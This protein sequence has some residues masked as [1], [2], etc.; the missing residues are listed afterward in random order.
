MTDEAIAALLQA[1]DETAWRRICDD[2]G[3]PLYRYCYWLAGA[4]AAAAED[5]RQETFLAAMAG[6]AG[7]RGEVPLFAW[8]SGIARHKASDARRRRRRHMALD[9]AGDAPAADPSPEAG[10]LAAERSAGVVETLWSLPPD[11]RIALLARY[12]E[13]ESVECVAARLGRSYK[14]A[15]SVLSRARQAF[16]RTLQKGTQAWGT[17]F[18]TLTKRS[19]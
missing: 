19:S 6:I 10:A 14:A 9:E 2:L 8:L 3:A 16:F 11:Y 18:R 4:D 13:E 1:G 7:Y 5:L 12:M 17:N 15:E